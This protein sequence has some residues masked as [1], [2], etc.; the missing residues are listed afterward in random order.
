MVPSH[1]H[2]SGSV[3]SASALDAFSKGTTTAVKFFTCAFAVMA[4][5]LV[6]AACNN[7]NPSL[8]P[9]PGPT[10]VLPSGTQSALVYPAPNATAVPDT[11]GQVIIGS[12]AALPSTWDV[13]LVATAFPAVYGNPFQTATPPFPTPNATPSFANPVYQKSDFA[14]NAPTKVVYSVYLNDKSSNCTPY[15]PIGQFVTQ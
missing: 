10:C 6:L 1:N 2:A 7:S 5:A 15:G 14:G 3:Q 11:F 12:T 9:T 4:A 13:A 8:G